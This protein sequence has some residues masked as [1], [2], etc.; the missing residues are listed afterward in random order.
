[1]V[2]DKRILFVRD[3]ESNIQ[4]LY[5]YKYEQL[6]GNRGT[7]VSETKNYA[8]V[9]LHLE[10]D[11]Q[12]KIPSQNLDMAIALESKIRLAKENFDEKLYILHNYK[13]EEN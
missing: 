9:I 10:G 4:V 8:N 5:E 3:I 7:S 13:E 2:T 12:F 11:K 1:M 6:K